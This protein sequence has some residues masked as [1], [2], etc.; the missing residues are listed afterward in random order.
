MGKCPHVFLFANG[1]CI[2]SIVTVLNVN[3]KDY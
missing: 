3:A 1:D 2:I